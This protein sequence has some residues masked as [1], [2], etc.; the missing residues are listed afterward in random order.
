MR[1]PPCLGSRIIHLAPDGPATG[2]SGTEQLE[3]RTVPP[4]LV[5][6]GA[7]GDSYTVERGGNNWTAQLA[8]GRHFNFGPSHPVDGAVVPW[9]THDYV[10]TGYPREM[11]GGAVSPAVA[12]LAAQVKAGK[13]TLIYLDGVGNDIG[14]V[15]PALYQ[16]SLAGPALS[17][18]ID[19]EV[20]NVCAELDYLSA[21]GDVKFVLEN[22]GDVGTLPIFVQNVG[23][24]LHLKPGENPDVLKKQR[25]SAAIREINARLQGLADARGIPVVDHFGWA[26]RLFDTSRRLIVGGL[27]IDNAP[28]FPAL[29]TNVVTDPL[30]LFID[31][32][33]VGPVAQGLKANV[34]LDAIRQAYGVAIAPFTDQEI[35][36]YAYQQARQ[37]PPPFGDATY[38]D[39]SGLVHYRHPAAAANARGDLDERRD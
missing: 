9:S 38:Y 17:T 8:T 29:S 15:Y 37:P 31:S 12:A 33:H 24:I 26:Q 28:T 14:Q 13:V 21:S 10:L 3:D 27:R 11:S 20:A 30:H 6:V 22:G 35:L 19:N 18:F 16:G 2:P 4:T 7:V 36:T 34:V 32:Q 23:N 39:V 5:G 25:A 1:H